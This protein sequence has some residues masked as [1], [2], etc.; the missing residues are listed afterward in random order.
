MHRGEQVKTKVKE[1]DSQAGEGGQ[2]QVPT[3]VDLFEENRK[4]K[5]DH[6]IKLYSV[7]MPVRARVGVC[8]CVCEGMCQ[9]NSPINRT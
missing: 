2:V 9:L 7:C 1:K 6:V 3:D 5:C 8:A 4:H